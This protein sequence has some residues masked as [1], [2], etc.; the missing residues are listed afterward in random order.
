MLVAVGATR[1]ARPPAAARTGATALRCDCAALTGGEET[2]KRATRGFTGAFCTGDGSI[3]LAHRAHFIKLGA[4]IFAYILINRHL[5]S[6]GFIFLEF[7]IDG[8][9]CN[10]IFGSVNM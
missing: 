9:Y 4:A 8:Y 1:T 6:P 2:G 10:S 7:Y 5:S 3:S